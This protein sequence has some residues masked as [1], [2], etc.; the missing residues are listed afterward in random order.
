MQHKNQSELLDHLVKS[1]NFQRIDLFHEKKHIFD[2]YLFYYFVSGFDLQKSGVNS[3]K[4]ER[5]RKEVRRVENY[6]ELELNPGK[7]QN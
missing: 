6:T 2:S 4:E 5:F 3:A 1:L 7:F